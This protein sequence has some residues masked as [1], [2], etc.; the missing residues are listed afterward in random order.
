MKT[1]GGGWEGPIKKNGRRK[2][3]GENHP[4]QVRDREGRRVSEHWREPEKANRQTEK[5][6]RT[7]GKSTR[8]Q[9]LGKRVSAQLEVKNRQVKIR[10]GAKGVDPRQVRFEPGG[11]KGSLAI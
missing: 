1:K 2:R 5:I 8:E 6:L 9:N 7:T 4:R 11:N 3:G 10:N